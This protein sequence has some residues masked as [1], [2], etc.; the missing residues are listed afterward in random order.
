MSTSARTTAAPAQRDQP[1]RRRDQESPP[2]AKDPRGFAR[3]AV[4]GVVWSLL[5]L[6]LAVVAGHDVLVQ[7]EAVSGSAWVQ[8]ALESVDGQQPVYWWVIVA[9]AVALLGLLLVY[10]ALR[11]RPYQGRQLEAQTGVFLLDRGLRNLAEAVAEDTDGVDSASA[12][13]GARTVQVEVRGLSPERDSGLEDRVS[14]ALRSRLELLHDPP[15][16]QVRD[17]GR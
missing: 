8:Q 3:V 4:L 2:A 13:T 14:E 5:L 16:V 10:V 7:V 9:V 15:R 6:A 12:R 11:P 1:S 17:T